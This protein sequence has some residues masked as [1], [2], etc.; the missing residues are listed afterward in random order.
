M[1]SA[2]CIRLEIPSGLGALGSR[3]LRNRN[4]LT[5]EI[6]IASSSSP[7]AIYGQRQQTH[8]RL[9]LSAAAMIAFMT[10]LQ[11]VKRTQRSMGFLCANQQGGCTSAT[12]PL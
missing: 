5:Y 9:S 4:V 8:M 6:S 10:I 2:G 7:I 12:E 1:K 11:S 3:S